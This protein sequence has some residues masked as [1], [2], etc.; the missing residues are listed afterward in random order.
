MRDA[1]TTVIIQMGIP[2]K[3]FLKKGKVKEANWIAMHE[4]AYYL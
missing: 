1:A 4:L 3:G 2:E